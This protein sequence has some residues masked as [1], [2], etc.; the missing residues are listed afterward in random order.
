MFEDLDKLL[1]DK[2]KF[3]EELDSFISIESIASNKGAVAKI[4]EKLTEKLEKIGA[5]VKIVKI[6]NSN[7]FVLAQL[8][9]GKKSLLI[10]DHYDVMSIGDLNEWHIPPFKL[11][12]KGENLFG[13]GTA[14]NKGHL[15]LRLQAIEWILKK[16]KKLPIKIKLVIE[17]EEEIGSPHIHDFSNKYKKFLENN[18]L[19]LWESGDV[20]EKG[21]PNMFLGM[22]GIAYLLLSCY[23]GKNDL[24]SGYASLVES[25]V[26]RLIKALNT[27]RDSQGNV[28]IEEIK[29]QIRKPTAFEMNLIK[30]HNVSKRSL[31]NSL[32]RRYFLKKDNLKNILFNHYFGV[33]CNICGIWAGSIDKKEIKTVLPNKAFAKIDLRLIEN[34]DSKSIKKIIRRHLDKAGF[35]DIEIVEIINEPVAYTDFND[36]NFKKAIKIIEQSYKKKVILTPYAKGSG[37]MYYIAS[38]FNIPAIQLGAQNLSSNIHGPNENIKYIDYFKALKATIDLILNLA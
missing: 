37:P 9:E 22:K 4:V 11:T 34:I 1:K 16:Y 6:K 20:D 36:N 35:N 13:R 14:D 10:Y 23:V 27:L 12:K 15:I 17:G 26:W 21:Q 19:C 30:S 33:T 24:H 2:K 3:L 29:K 5:D 18:H 8:G 28:L 7:P 25:P 38:Q 31:L 32:G